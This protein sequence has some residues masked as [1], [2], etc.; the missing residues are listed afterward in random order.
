ML[1]EPCRAICVPLVPR[2]SVKFTSDL[3]RRT[4]SIRFLQVMQ[5]STFIIS[6]LIVAG[7]FRVRPVDTLVKPSSG[8]LSWE[9]RILLH[10]VVLGDFAAN[11]P[12]RQIAVLGHGSTQPFEG[13]TDIALP[14]RDSTTNQ[15]CRQS[16]SQIWRLSLG[17]TE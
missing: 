5:P 15:D 16:S 10:S 17:T 7:K 12:N 1:G 11:A 8:Q 14:Q 13:R 4:V 9:K 6:I 2:R 3:L